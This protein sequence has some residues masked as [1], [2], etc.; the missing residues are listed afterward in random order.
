MEHEFTD[1]IVC[2]YCGREQ[3]D[4]WEVNPGKEDLGIQECFCGKKFT[5]SR[6]TKVNYSSYK[7]PC[8]NGEGKHDWRP[9]IGVPKE[10][11]KDK[12]R[13]YFCGKEK[14]KEK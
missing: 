11:F 7:N 6:H 2:P 8:L 13:C 1:E 5:A 4:S 14:L 10:Y 9:I 3:G 12:Y